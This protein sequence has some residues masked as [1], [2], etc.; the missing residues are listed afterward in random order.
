MLMNK[1]QLIDF[2]SERY[3]DQDYFE[4]TVSATIPQDNGALVGTTFGSAQHMIKNQLNRETH[5]IQIRATVVY[6]E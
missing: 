5:E 2:I 4:L 1:Q 6:S 3:G